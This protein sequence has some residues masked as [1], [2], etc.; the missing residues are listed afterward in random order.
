[1]FSK[2]LPINIKDWP[3]FFQPVAVADSRISSEDKLSINEVLKQ[4]KNHPSNIRRASSCGLHAED[5]AGESSDVDVPAIEVVRRPM[6]FDIDEDD[7][8]SLT[9]AGRVPRSA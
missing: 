6:N 8:P 3:I 5:S 1:M 9:S 7:F 4:I 2:Q